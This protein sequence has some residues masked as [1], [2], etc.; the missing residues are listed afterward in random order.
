MVLSRTEPTWVTCPSSKQSLRSWVNG[1]T[2]ISESGACLSIKLGG[3]V[4]SFTQTVGNKS[5][6]GQFLQRKVY[7]LLLEEGEW[8]LDRC[9]LPGAD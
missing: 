3:E 6:R 5:G 8:V 2:W 7:V 9:V 4:V 1:I